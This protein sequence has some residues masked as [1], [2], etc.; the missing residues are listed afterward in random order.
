MHAIVLVGAYKMSRTATI[1]D[2][3]PLTDTVHPQGAFH[4]QAGLSRGGSIRNCPCP[5][6]GSTSATVTAMFQMHTWLCKP[7]MF[8]LLAQ[9]LI[10]LYPISP[11][12]RPALYKEHMALPQQQVLHVERRQLYPA[13]RL[14]TLLSDRLLMNS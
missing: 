13:N 9:L 14:H 11:A 6:L 10:S 4:G 2:V 5:A 8:H 7:R 12:I 3:T 1:S